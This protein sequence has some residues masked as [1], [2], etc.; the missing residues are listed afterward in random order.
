MTPYDHR[1]NPIEFAFNQVKIPWLCSNCSSTTLVH[2]TKPW[3]RPSSHCH[4]VPVHAS[5]VKHSCEQQ[6]F[7][8]EVCVEEKIVRALENVT[9]ANAHNYGASTATPAAV[10]IDRFSWVLALIRLFFRTQNT[11][12]RGADC[13]TLP[14]FSRTVLRAPPLQR[15][16]PQCAE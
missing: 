16:W 15:H 5:Q 13:S 9:A 4:T 6:M 10:K 7:D 3:D 2:S 14:A 8:Y 1:T 11:K 12:R